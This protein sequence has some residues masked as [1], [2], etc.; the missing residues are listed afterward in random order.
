MVIYGAT[1]FL[2]AFLLFVIQPLLGKCLLP[3]YGGSPAVWTSCMLFFQV[4]LLAGYAYAHFLAVRISG[5]R[6]V[7]I[8]LLL[9]AASL[10]T[11]PVL[12]SLRWKPS[13]GRWPVLMIPGLLA[14]CAGV[15]YTLLAA[16]TPL[17]Q[18]WFAQS[19]PG[20]SSYRLYSVS[21]A[22]SL[23]AVLGYPFLIEPAFSLHVQGTLWSWGYCVFAAACVI[24][25]E[26][27]RRAL[28]MRPAP[29]RESGPVSSTAISS[30]QPRLFQ[31]ALWLML[32]ACSSLVLLSTTNQLCQDV[33]AIPLLWVLPLGLYLLSF[34]LCFASPRFY[35]RVF[36]GVLLMAAS[37]WSCQLLFEGVFAG[38]SSQIASICVTL[39]AACMVCHGELAKSKPEPSHLTGYYVMIAAGGALGSMFVAI[40]CPLIF[41][42]YWEYHLGLLAPP[43]LLL[44]ILIGESGGGPSRSRLAACLVLGSALLALAFVLEEHLRLVSTGNLE[45][46]RSFYGVL[47]VFEEDRGDP[48]FHRVTLMNGRIQHGFQ[49]QAPFRR[50]WPTSYF[51]P[52]S[53]AGLALRY[54]P[55]RTAGDPERRSLRVGVVGL[56]AG[57]L[58][59]YGRPRDYIR[60]YE[61]NPDV[62]RVARRYFSFLR[63]CPARLDIV[64]GDARISMERERND[65]GLQGFDVLA[66]DAFSGDAI[67]IH[68]LTRECLDLY[69]SHVRPDGILALHVSSRYFDLRPVA[70]GFEGA[71]PGL[72]ALLVSNTLNRNQGIEASDWVILTSNEQFLNT[73]QVQSAV[74]PWRAE[75]PIA[76]AWTD[77]RSNLFQLLRR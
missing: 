14:M 37:A 9:L 1:L 32:P 39:V 58:A 44:V 18:S 65:G 73:S 70:R 67:P 42:G 45:M 48:R 68:L 66:I 61:I 28:E 77:D 8:H 47:R 36:F 30:G 19:R 69:L 25:G 64:E 53:G 41:K 76:R 57:T 17:L 2:S 50:G 5:R 31:R 13:A 75:D 52:E 33:A 46:S 27:F 74:R 49:Y 12:P 20:G 55:N 24:C 4:F 11:L 56:G 40:A 54:H 63:D 43:L 71:R 6:Q 34:V 22:G 29:A 16:T 60:F 7:L 62:I 23:L 21:N 59:A 3:W 26:R 15:P 72:R 38:L 35:S 51:G 10:A